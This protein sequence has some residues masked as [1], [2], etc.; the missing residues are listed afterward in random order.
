MAR[1]WSWKYP[2]ENLEKSGNFD[3]PKYRQPSGFSV[4]GADWEGIPPS[5]WKKTLEKQIELEQNELVQ[6]KDLKETSILD[7]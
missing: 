5:S 1:L 7:K 2:L 6:K 4:V 3:V